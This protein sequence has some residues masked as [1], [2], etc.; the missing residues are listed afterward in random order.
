MR[1]H[2]SRLDG[3]DSLDIPSQVVA[4]Q[5][6]L[7]VGESVGVN[8]LV[9]RLGKSVVESLGQVARDQWI[10]RADEVIERHRR[11]RLAQRVL[12]EVL[13]DE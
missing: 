13:A 8:P 4:G 11:L 3:G 5:F 10:E 12:I 2:G 6:Y 9:Q 1:R 7:E